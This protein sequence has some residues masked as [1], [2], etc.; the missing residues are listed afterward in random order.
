MV[1]RSSSATL[2][3]HVGALIRADILDGAWEPG[4]GLRIGELRARYDASST[5]VREA[6]M[7]LSVDRLVELKPN[8]GF[9]VRSLTVDEFADLTELRC[10][11][12]ELG[13][14]LAIERGDVDWEAA[15]TAAHHTL[16]RTAPWR[17]DDPSRLASNWIAVHHAFHASLLAASGVPMILDLARSV[18]D[19]TALQRTLAAAAHPRDIAAEDRAILDAVLARDATTAARLLRTHYEETLEA[20]RRA[21]AAST[22]GS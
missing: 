7:A 12:E 10:R 17:T 16:T 8:R 15:A 11:V 5:V 20:V 22:A 6:L 9:Y 3:A 13:I 2:S 18:E 14:A 4:T 21:A 1:Q 19:A